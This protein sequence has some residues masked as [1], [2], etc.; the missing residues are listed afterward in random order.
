MKNCMQLSWTYKRH[1]IRVDRKAV[2]N[3]LKIYGVRG[4]LVAGVEAFYREA[5]ACVS[6]DGELSEFSCW[7]ETIMCDVTMGV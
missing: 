2:W 3:V 5:S 6:V 7:V 4:Q 1:M